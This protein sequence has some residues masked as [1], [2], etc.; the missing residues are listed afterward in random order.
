[1]KVLRASFF[2]KQAEELL[3]ESTE[4]ILEK[5][6]GQGAEKTLKELN[7]KV[8]GKEIEIQAIAKKNQ[9]SGELEVSV[10]RVDKT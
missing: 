8:S 9:F 7:E 4:K 10:R 1:S 5:I 6:E 3:E 2:G